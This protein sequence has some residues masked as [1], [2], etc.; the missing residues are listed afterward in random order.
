MVHQIV[1]RM[2][3]DWGRYLRRVFIY[4]YIAT[5]PSDTLKLCSA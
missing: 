5:F 3:K 1:L 4:S 2:V